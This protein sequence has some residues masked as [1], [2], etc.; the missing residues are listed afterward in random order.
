MGLGDALGWLGEG[1]LGAGGCAD[2]GAELGR[3]DGARADCTG[4]GVE[5]EVGGWVGPGP[6]LEL[7]L[8]DVALL[9]DDECDEDDEAAFEGDELD[10][11]LDELS[12]NASD[13]VGV[14]VG[15]SDDAAPA[16][17]WCAGVVPGTRIRPIPTAIRLTPLTVAW[18][19]VRNFTSPPRLSHPRCVRT[20]GRQCDTTF[21]VR[22]ISGQA[23]AS[24]SFVADG[25][26]ANAGFR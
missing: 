25:A 24:A 16:S 11:A 4:E 6:E 26:E 10:E 13:V 9:G 5:D 18:R 8:D 12:L 22:P 15:V 17:V 3:E 19:W 21:A 7:L 20:P 1:A 2:D 14:G 23:G